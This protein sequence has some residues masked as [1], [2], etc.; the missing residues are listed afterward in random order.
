MAWFAADE[1]H[2]VD[3]LALPVTYIRRTV[4]DCQRRAD[5]TLELSLE[6][7]PIHED[8]LALDQ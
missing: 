2:E 4:R 7:V 8:M 1:F 5:A 6:V 3:Q